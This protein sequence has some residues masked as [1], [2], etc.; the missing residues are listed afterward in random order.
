MYST[1]TPR[2][3]MALAATG[4]VLQNYLLFFVGAGLLA[5]S[6]VLFVI[7]NYKNQNLSK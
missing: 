2:P 1:P 4:F 6:L 7:S 3:G 5:L